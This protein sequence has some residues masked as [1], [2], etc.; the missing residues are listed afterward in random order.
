VYQWCEFK[1]RRGKNKNLTALKSNSNTVWFNFQI[2]IYIIWAHKTSLYPPF[3]L[4]KCMY[5]AKK[6]EQSRICVL[7][8]SILPLSIICVLDFG[9]VPTVRYFLFFIKVYIYF[10]FILAI[11]LAASDYPFGIISDLSYL[12]PRCSSLN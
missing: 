9:S 7:V 1:S 12:F 11:V 3:F 5:Q 8:V 10:V 2:Y 4:L 6:I